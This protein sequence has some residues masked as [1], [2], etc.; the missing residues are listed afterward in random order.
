M[1]EL[2]QLQAALSEAAR[3]RPRRR[4]LRRAAVVA[5]AAICVV[6]VVALADV[7]APGSRND[8]IPAVAPP[9]PSTLRPLDKCDSLA[10][11][12]EPPPAELL[13]RFEVLRRPAGAD[14]RP[15]AEALR[16]LAGMTGVHI[17]AARLITKNRPGSRIWMVPVQN[18]LPDRARMD[19][20]GREPDH[21][22]RKRLKALPRVAFA[23]EPDA[24]DV[25]SPVPLSSTLTG[26]AL[27]GAACQGPNRSDFALFAVMA[28]GVN[29]ITVTLRDGTTI[30]EPVIDNN[31]TV[32]VPNPQTAGQKAA[33]VSWTTGDGIPL[34]MSSQAARLR[35]P[36]PR[37]P[38]RPELSAPRTPCRVRVARPR[39]RAPLGAR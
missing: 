36:A 2:P 7:V 23:A 20:C 16:G 1:T 19:G 30:T 35:S 6:S 39:R 26:A 11:T 10:T 31:A 33:S 27:T 14:D 17:E 22:P 25:P 5:A 18:L 28:D 4:R 8:E 32:L 24:R 3:R 21:E 9:S 12:D 38:T 15:T 29:E 37:R 34:P 13:N